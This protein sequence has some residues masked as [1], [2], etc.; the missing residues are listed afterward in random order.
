MEFASLA[1]SFLN[2]HHDAQGLKIIVCGDKV[3]HDDQTFVPPQQQSQRFFIPLHIT[4]P[5]K[6]SLISCTHFARAEAIAQADVY[7][8][9]PEI[10][11]K[12]RRL[13]DDV[14]QISEASRVCTGEMKA[15]RHATAS[16]ALRRPQRTVSTDLKLR[17]DS[18]KRREQDLKHRSED[19][20]KRLRSIQQKEDQ[21]CWKSNLPVHY[22]T[23]SWHTPTV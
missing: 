20:E 13:P 9:I 17:E 23:K 15:S 4:P 7:V 16:A 12:R 8:E 19:L 1:F 6:C 21:L 5:H 11:T 10:S 2:V 18:L 3:I 22:V 14:S